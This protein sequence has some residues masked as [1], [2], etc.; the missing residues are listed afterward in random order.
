[1]SSCQVITFAACLLAALASVECVDHVIYHD[2]LYHQL[3]GYPIPAG[4]AILNPR[5]FG[6]NEVT[7]GGDEHARR[8]PEG[9]FSLETDS[10]G[11]MFF[12]RQEKPISR[13]RLETP[14]PRQRPLLTRPSRPRLQRPIRGPRLVRPSRPRLQRPIPRP[15]PKRPFRLPRLQTPIGY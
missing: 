4:A 11:R 15:R 14:I 5:F 1:M 2:R 8:W 12:V 7:R 9:K 3:M 13:P 6:G 10:R